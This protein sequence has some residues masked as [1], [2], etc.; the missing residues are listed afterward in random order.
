MTPQ[1]IWDN[2]PPPQKAALCCH[3]GTPLPIY[4]HLNFT[5]ASMKALQRKGLWYSS[6]EGGGPTPLGQRVVKCA[7]KCPSMEEQIRVVNEMSRKPKPVPRRFTS[8]QLHKPRYTLKQVEMML[9]LDETGVN[10]SSEQAYLRW[11]PRFRVIL[12]PLCNAGVVDTGHISS[13]SDTIYYHLT[14][15]GLDDVE[16]LRER[17]EA[18][19]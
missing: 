13:R 7:P 4:T 3:T 8:V 5:V 6:Q 11:G 1:Q 17:L 10:N 12:H 2:L 16:V 15:D 19:A 9:W 18:S 14:P